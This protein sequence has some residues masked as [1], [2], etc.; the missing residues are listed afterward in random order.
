MINQFLTYHCTVPTF[1]SCTKFAGSPGIIHAACPIATQFTGYGC[2]D[3]LTTERSFGSQAL[4]VINVFGVLFDIIHRSGQMVQELNECTVHVAPSL[5]FS[6]HHRANPET[7]RISD[8][9]LM[10]NDYIFNQL[11]VYIPKHPY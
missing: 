8:C 6:H 4:C 1:N 10:V 2:M 3:D 5:H 7:N 9:E 11:I